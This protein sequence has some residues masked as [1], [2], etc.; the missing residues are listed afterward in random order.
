MIDL[1]MIT[2]NITSIV[3]RITH[4]LKSRTAT[5]AFSRALPPFS[6]RSPS[7][8]GLPRLRVLAALASGPLAAAPGPS[9]T[10]GATGSAL[11]RLRLHSACI[12]GHG[13][14]NLRHARAHQHRRTH[15]PAQHDSSGRRS[16]R[17]GRDPNPLNSLSF[18]PLFAFP[19]WRFPGGTHL[20]ADKRLEIVEERLHGSKDPQGV[21]SKV[22]LQH[23]LI[24]E[25]M[26][27]QELLV[28]Q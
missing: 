18:H 5:S 14:H 25:R 1:F 16:F 7:V 12:F 6:P 13:W 21:V 24:V 28:A 19:F 11:G 4:P 15:P 10:S 17:H 26:D 20:L 8:F 27:D 22:W 3:I 9:C 23:S 2:S